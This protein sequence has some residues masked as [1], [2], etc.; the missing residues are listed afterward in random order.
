VTTPAAKRRPARLPQRLP[1][2]F[3]DVVILVLGSY[4]FLHELL[5]TGP[6]RPM[7]LFASLAA[8]GLPLALRADER[9]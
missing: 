3:R 7:Y 6:E 1:A 5:R 8:L 9:D 4:G 2:I